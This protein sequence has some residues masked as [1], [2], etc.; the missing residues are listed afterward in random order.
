MAMKRKSVV[1]MLFDAM[2]ASFVDS[3]AAREFAQNLLELNRENNPLTSFG[4]VSNLGSLEVLNHSSSPLTVPQLISLHSTREGTFEF[5]PIGAPGIYAAMSSIH[6]A[7]RK[8]WEKP[9]TRSALLCSTMQR[10]IFSRANFAACA[11]SKP[12]DDNTE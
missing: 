11:N 5:Q 4:F 10:P 2:C 9:P 3:A 8:T 12:T 7:D 1:R 6:L